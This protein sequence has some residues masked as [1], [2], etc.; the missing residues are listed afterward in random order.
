MREDLLPIL[1]CP[2]C[3]ASLRLEVRERVGDRIAEGTLWCDACGRAFPI[4]RGIPRFVAREN[5]AASFGAQWKRFRP[6]CIPPSRS[7]WMRRAFHF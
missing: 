5:Y 6:L 3:R 4:E 2:A 1:R 7:R